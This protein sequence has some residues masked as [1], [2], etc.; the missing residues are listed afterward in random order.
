MNKIQINSI[1]EKEYFHIYRYMKGLGFGFHYDYVI[2]NRA[3]NYIY[4]YVYME[5]TC[6]D[7]IEMLNRLAPCDINDKNAVIAFLRLR[8]SLE[9]II[10]ES[11]L[12]PNNNEQQ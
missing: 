4:T 2:S 9:T 1:S 6:A 8:K 7:K 3:I 11:H 10:P 5:R 12:N